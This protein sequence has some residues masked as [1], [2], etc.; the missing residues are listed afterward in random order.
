M[1][2]LHILNELKPSGAEVMLRSAACYW[3]RRDIE[4]DILCMG[5]VR[6]SYATT[7]EEA[8]YR[9]VHM[10]SKASFQF[11]YRLY[12]FLKNHKYDAVHIHTER[13]NFWYALTAFVSGNRR[14]VRTVHNVFPFKGVLRLERYV[15]RWIMRVMLGVKMVSI[16]NSVKNT[17]LETFRNVSILVPNWFDTGKFVPCKN[18]DE[19]KASRRVLGISE[20]TTVFTSV[21]ACWSFKNH[22]SIIKAIATL[23]ESSRLVYLHVGP[24]TEGCPERVLAE[25]SGLI[26]R[27][28]FLGSILDVVP[29]L[30]ATDV[31]LMPSL[32]E[33]FGV[34]AAE[35]MGAGLP[36]ILSDVPGLCDFR[37]V[38]NDIYWVK[39]TP[40]SIA[41][42]MLDFVNMPQFRQREIGSRLSMCVHEH[43]GMEKGAG[44]YAQLYRGKRHV[45]SGL[46]RSDAELQQ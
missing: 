16:G 15:Q 24:E 40:E 25:S 19:A 5:D 46:S 20:G 32:Y 33:G 8:G 2:V 35:A 31:Y 30:N 41:K 22:S 18:K 23:P 9:V 39:P 45:Q 13:G 36:A 17:E 11:I 28:R 10:P 43:F 12:R 4:S 38:C 37:D 34:A 7:L 1:R 42:A 3:R 21:G 44:A 27:V 14:L 26:E 6:G 29:I